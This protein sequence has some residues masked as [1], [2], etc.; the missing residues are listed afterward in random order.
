MRNQI[1][2]VLVQLSAMGSMM[3][4]GV[5]AGPIEQGQLTGMIWDDQK[6]DYVPPAPPKWSTYN[7]GKGDFTNS[8]WQSRLQPPDEF[9]CVLVVQNGGKVGVA[10]FNI[11]LRRVEQYD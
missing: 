2:S 10:S 1:F 4:V 7:F 5:K 6:Q 8:D 9:G 11:F 3:L